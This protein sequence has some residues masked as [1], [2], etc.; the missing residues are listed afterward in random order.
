MTGWGGEAAGFGK[1]A[2]PLTPDEEAACWANRT[3]ENV[4]R[5]TLRH[6]PLAIKA[7]CRALAVAGIGPD[8][9]EIFG[10]VLLGLRRAVMGFDPPRGFAF[11]TYAYRGLVQGCLRAR[12]EQEK[13][14]GP[15]L[16]DV[17]EVPDER[18]PNMA[19]VLDAR[20]L[21]ARLGGV[22]SP[23]EQGIV[24]L[25]LAGV[26]LKEIAQRIGRTRERVRQIE[27]GALKQMAEA[28]RKG[29]TSRSTTGGNWPNMPVEEAFR[30]AKKGSENATREAVRDAEAA[31]LRVVSI[32]GSGHGGRVVVADVEKAVAVLREAAEAVE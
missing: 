20:G 16:D 28:A 29:T 25:R 22:L 9:D 30:L 21:A 5:L 15:G 17:A 24:A 4:W 11:S 27:A 8:P 7:A 12:R 32:K 23:R 13:R 14:R 31:G 1:L 18:P 3:E 6:L 19:E 2:A 26:T 10:T